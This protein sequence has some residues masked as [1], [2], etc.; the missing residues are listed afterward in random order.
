MYE[1][2][3]IAYEEFMKQKEKEK[4]DFK[5]LPLNE[6]LPK[7]VKKMIYIVRCKTGGSEIYAKM[8]LSMLPN[9][10]YAV[11]INYWLYKSDSDDFQTM[12]ELMQEYNSM[13][14]E[15]EKLV[16]PYVDELKKYLGLEN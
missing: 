2:K 10:D 15:Y 7:T 6:K 13:K 11:C 8:L 14:W 5:A 3:E 12:L 16:S 9:Y 1:K 4:E